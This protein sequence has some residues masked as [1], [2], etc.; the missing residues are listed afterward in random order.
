MKINADHEI[1]YT[2]VRVRGMDR[3]GWNC[4]CGKK[5]R[6]ANGRRLADAARNHQLEVLN[7]PE[8]S[9]KQVNRCKLRAAEAMRRRDRTAA[10]TAA[11]DAFEAADRVRAHFGGR[12][13]H[14]EVVK[15][16]L[17]ADRAAEFAARTTEE[18]S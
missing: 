11:A 12:E 7:P 15:A 4:T 3:L 10:L 5:S 2:T 1:T 6:A 14:P 17:S 13:D 8:P 18:K 16:Y 9:V